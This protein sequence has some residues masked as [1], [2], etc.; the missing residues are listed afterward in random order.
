M[1]KLFISAALLTLISGSALA[2]SA[3]TVADD[4]I[5]YRKDAFHLIRHNTADIGDMVQG[6]VAFDAARVQKR[7][8]ALVALT[9]LPWEA[10]SVEGANKASG[11]AKAEIWAN[12]SDFTAKADKFQQDAKALQTAAA[13]ADQAKIKAAFATFRGNCKSCHE[14]YKAD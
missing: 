13:T 11:D 1:K 10:F 8:D 9:A 2:A 6:K 4:A 12:F 7:A 5:E 14:K 3:F